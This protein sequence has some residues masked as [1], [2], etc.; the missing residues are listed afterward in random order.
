[1]KYLET[2]MEKLRK[3]SLSFGY[4]CDGCGKEVFNYQ[5]QPFCDSCEQKMPKNITERCEKCGRKTVTGGVCWN[6][7][8]KSPSFTKGVSPFVYKGKIAELVNR[9]KNG[10]R[11][12]SYF[13]GKKMTESLLENYP[14]ISEFDRGRYALN[15]EN[16]T[17]SLLVL[18]VPLY[19]TDEKRRGYNQALDLAKAV[20]EEPKKRGYSVFMDEETLLKVK[21]TQSQKKLTL[22]ER[23]E[24]LVGV[25]HVHK[26][27][28]VKN[29]TILLIDDIMTTGATGDECAARLKGAGAKEVVFLTLASLPELKPKAEN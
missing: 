23:A 4:T 5:A 9:L 16:K 28:E 19:I 8:Q 11:Y 26:R 18:P 29:R 3:R 10:D 21:S 1:M 27:T 20:Y 7:K 14:Q 2:L 25:F 15:D 24:N 13:F 17:K 6:C 22:F 12:L